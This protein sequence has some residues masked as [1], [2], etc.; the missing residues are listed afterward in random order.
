MKKFQLIAK[1]ND[2]PGNRKISEFIKT[3][4]STLVKKG[5]HFDFKIAKESEIPLL[6]KNGITRLPACTP[7]GEKHLVGPDQIMSYLLKIINSEKKKKPVLSHEEKM[8][9][10]YE[11]EMSLEAIEREKNE[12]N[13][14]MNTD[15]TTVLSKAS[16]AQQKR[17][18]MFIKEKEKAGFS[19]SGSRIPHQKRNNNIIQ[20]SKPLDGDEAMLAAKMEETMM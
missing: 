13:N 16:E 8:R 9:E 11:N 3:H 6:I 14:D 1:D 4:L 19:P 7:L 10:Y 18:E 15:M 17:N 12:E 20:A 5:C 2:T